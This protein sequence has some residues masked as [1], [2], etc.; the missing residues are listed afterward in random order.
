MA[1]IEHSVE[2]PASKSA[3]GER[4]LLVALRALARFEPIFYLAFAGTCTLFVAC[5]FYASLKL[6]T[7]Y[8]YA[9]ARPDLY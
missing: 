6:Q 9:W 3:A 2:Q 8:A 7:L 5:R 1:E 4:A